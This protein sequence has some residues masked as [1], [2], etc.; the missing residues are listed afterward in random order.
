[1]NMSC[2][3]YILNEMCLRVVGGGGGMWT[4]MSFGHKWIFKQ[5]QKLES[6]PQI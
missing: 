5:I 4:S 1:M 2:R 3:F 6:I